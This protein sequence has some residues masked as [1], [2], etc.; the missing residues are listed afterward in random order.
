MFEKIKMITTQIKQQ[1]PL[2]LN[3][4]NDVTMDFIANGLLSVG[5]SPVMSQAQEEIVDLMTLANT[6]VIN[7]G[8][9]DEKFIALCV[10]ACKA[11]NQLNK[12][13]IL[14]PVGAGA[15]GYRTDA[16]KQLLNDFAIAIVRGNASEVMALAGLSVRTKGVDSSAAS[17]LAI[18]GAQIV[19]TSYAAAVVISGKTDIIVDAELLNQFERGSAFMPMITGSGCLLTAI[20]GA[21]HAVHVNRFEAACAAT[22]FYSMC[23]EVAAHTVN[24]PGSFKP[25]FLDALYT[26]SA[27]GEYA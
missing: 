15:T 12:P 26:T 3:I 17:E 27:R 7:L 4:T 1:R 16:C 5:A 6:V 23:G 14:D 24:G 22:L 13:I 25:K 9:L 18:E 8:T 2:V 10:A 11:A 20:V 19:S 21:F